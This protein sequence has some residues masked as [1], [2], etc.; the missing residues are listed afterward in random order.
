MGGQVDDRV[1]VGFGIVGPLLAYVCIGMSI[2]LSSWFS[3]QSSALSDLGHSVRSSVASIFNIGL[4]SAGFLVMIF[5]ITVF[6]KHAKYTS[7]WLLLSAFSLQLVA[8]FDEVY[9]FLHLAVSVLLFLCFGFTSLV[10]TLEKKSLL[11]VVVFIV[12]L[13]SWSVYGLN[14]FILGIAVPE[15]ISS[16]AVVSLIWRSAARIYSEIKPR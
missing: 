10:Y 5:A 2:A 4:L 11:G 13:V 7:F 9:G 15:T 12:N 8:T 16:I 14:I 3:W 6:R 1:Y